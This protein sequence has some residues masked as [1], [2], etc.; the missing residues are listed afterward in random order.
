MEELQFQTSDAASSELD[1][2]LSSVT[3]RL[4]V[5]VVYE[6]EHPEFWKHHEKLF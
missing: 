6:D 1:Q 3:C 2:S 4:P 5:H